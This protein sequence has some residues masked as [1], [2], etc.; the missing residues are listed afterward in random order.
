MNP[1]KF[2]ALSAAGYLSLVIIFGGSPPLEDRPL[3]KLLFV[4]STVEIMPLTPEQEGK[5]GWTP[6]SLPC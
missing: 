6:W 5:C 1:F 4:P 2:L 3:S